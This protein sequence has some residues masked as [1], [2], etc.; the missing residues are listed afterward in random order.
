LPAKNNRWFSGL[1]SNF[2]S[3][4]VFKSPIFV[5]L[6]VGIATDTPVFIILTSTCMTTTTTMTTFIL[7]QQ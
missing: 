2:F 3:T 6:D 4:S 1:T 7:G 5:V